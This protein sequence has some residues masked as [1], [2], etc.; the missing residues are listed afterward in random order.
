MDDGG[1]MD[2][3]ELRRLL[4]KSIHLPDEELIANDP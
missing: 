3:D 2:Y 4:L 1:V